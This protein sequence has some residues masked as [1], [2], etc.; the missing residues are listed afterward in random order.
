MKRK[1]KYFFILEDLISH[2]YLGN[3]F[4][5]EANYEKNWDF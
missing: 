1:Y 3:Q 2:Y 5:K 4:H